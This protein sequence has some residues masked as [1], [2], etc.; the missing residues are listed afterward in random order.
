MTATQKLHLKIG[1]MSCS[2]CAETIRKGVGRLAGVRRVSVSLSHEEALVEY[3]AES[4]RADDIRKRLTDLGYT[5]R[6]PTKVRTFEEEESEL[7]DARKKL[8]AASAATVIS[9]ALMTS[10]WLGVRRDW[11][12]FALLALALFTMFGPGWYIKKMA[13]HSLRRRILNQHNLLEFGAFAGLA[14]GLL[15]FV[16]AQF[17]TADFLAVSVFITTYHIASGYASLHVRTHSSRGVRRL[18]DLQPQTAT[19]L[20]EGQ[21]FQVAAEE[22]KVGEIVRVVPGQRIP[23]DGVVEEGASSVDRSLVTGESLPV[24]VQP[25]EEVIGGSLNQEGTLLIKVVRVGDESFLRKIARYVEEA[26]A[27]KP[28][29]LQLVDSVL[30]HYVPWV[31]LMAGAALLIWTVGAALLSGGADYV[32]AVFAMLAVL[33]MGYPCALGM[34]TP[35]AMIRGGGLAAER[36]ILMR[37][38]EAFQ[39]LSRAKL[40]VLDK[41][42]TVTMGK[43]QVVEVVPHEGG[44]ETRTVEVAAACEAHSEHPLGR[45]IVERAQEE[46]LETEEVTGFKALPGRGVE[47][48]LRGRRALVGKP[49][50]LQSSGI[51]LSSLEME[52]E[53]LQGEAKTVVAVSLGGEPVGLI[54]FADLP[55]EDATQTVEELR[56]MGV[57]TVMITGDNERTAAATA[58]WVG[59][60]RVHADVLP[61]KKAEM[62]R[63]MQES[64]RRVVMVGD[65]INDAP[66]LMQAD[67]GIA[68]GAG[69]DIAIESSDV[70]IIGDR[71][72]AVIDAFK[73]AK[74]AY[75]KTLQNVTLAFL[76]NGIGVPA[77]ITGL[78]HPVWAMI[79]MAASVT[80]V[81]INSFLGSVLPGR[82]TVPRVKVLRLQV[83]SM[84]CSSCLATLSDA[85][86]KVPG[87][88]RVSG[89]LEE[90]ILEVVLQGDA[91]A[92]EVRK[93]VVH[94]GHV[95]M[96]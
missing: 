61:Q 57:E 87:V 14:G 60:E 48:W 23:L 39:V 53:R 45:A 43:P 74:V 76:F 37:S 46:G 11:Y 79:A 50:F 28:G 34:A 24:E 15:G 32:R 84:H 55:K 72:R 71:L 6:D 81:L 51:D 2:F 3:V 95:L 30:R 41:T 83:P 52:I 59:I 25:G 78:V 68:I 93:R 75:R 7:Q 96:E 26:R 5:I 31:I 65:G 73:V 63:E 67:V 20:R 42:G 29:I 1:G 22:V 82:D 86:G 88:E 17:P 21:E 38:S 33:V 49:G 47:A 69:T 80:T 92:E 85:V 58:E 56:R 19:V 40:L 77:A 70:I 36:G 16:F 4:L 27:L 90:K 35:L 66:A 8:Y 54:A 89:H 44:D 64:G 62:I 94:A 12:P 91:V 10:M 18:L 9:I 13:Y